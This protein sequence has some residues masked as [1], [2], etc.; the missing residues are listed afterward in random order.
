MGK[1]NRDLDNYV[2]SKLNLNISTS[3][4]YTLV[5]KYY[6]YKLS[7][8]TFQNYI[9]I[10][11]RKYRHKL[12]KP[13]DEIEEG[14]V[15]MKASIQ[16]LQDKNRI[17]NKILRGHDRYL[18]ATSELFDHILQKLKKLE[19]FKVDEIERKLEIKKKTAIVQ[20]TDIHFGEEVELADSLGFNQYGVKQASQ[21]L[22]KMARKIEYFLGDSVSDI[23][24]ALTGDLLNS[25]RRPDEFLTNSGVRS[26]VYIQAME[27]LAGFLTDL[28]KRYNVTVLSVMGNESRMDENM[29][30]RDPIHNF[31]FL[32]HKG[33]S[34]LLSNCRPRIKFLDIERNFEKLYQVGG[35]N[36]LFFHGY[37]YK[38]TM[39][40]KVISKYNTVGKLIDYV[41][42]GHYH[43]T[44]IEDGQARGGSIVGGN[45]YSTY[46]LHLLS[47]ASQNL[48]V[49]EEEENIIKPSI[50]PIVI[51]L[52]NI[53]EDKMYKFDEDVCKIEGS[54]AWSL[55]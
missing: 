47:R 31:D 18:N 23:V 54:A 4:I 27:I 29:P 37:K 1:Q 41:I 36:V 55:S 48:F 30:F 7:R 15:K 14:L 44:N 38:Q 50:Y 5:Q 10:V 53:I 19:V 25:D 16:S 22:W 24:V 33:L 26:E 20:V 28:A 17:A 35:L 12:Y 21:R 6:G 8:K 46:G 49:I 40:S 51:D 39:L 34:M 11:R 3:D 42:T 43:S 32:I 2:I 13:S 45:F 52:Q 9:G